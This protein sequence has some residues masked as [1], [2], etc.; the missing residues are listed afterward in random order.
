L[1]NPSGKHSLAH[2]KKN[3]VSQSLSKFKEQRQYLN[4]QMDSGRVEIRPHLNGRPFSS[5]YFKA[6][7][8]MGKQIE[9]VSKSQNMQ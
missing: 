6:G 3:A 9:S 2:F 8:V 7:G 4:R 1:R 5:N